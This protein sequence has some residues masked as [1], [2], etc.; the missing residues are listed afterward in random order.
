MPISGQKIPGR[1]GRLAPSP[2]GALHLGGAAT[3]L[4][5]WLDAR[6]AGSSLVLRMEDIDRP[7]VVPGAEK[8]LIED[9]RW[10][11]ID[12]DEGPD[13]GGQ[14]GPY[15]QSERL[16]LYEQILTS[17]VDRKLVYWCDCSR[18]EIARVSSAPHLGE[19]GPPYP[20]TCRPYGLQKRRWKR[21]PAL[22]FAVPPQREIRFMD[23]VHGEQREVVSNSI[24]DFILRRGDGVF[25]YQFVVVVDDW[26]MGIES[27]IRGA[28]LL[29]STARQILLQE[30]M[31]SNIPIYLHTPILVDPNGQRLA[32]R[33]RGIPIADQR[34]AGRS[35]E[36][37]V[38]KLAACIGLH[39]DATPCTAKALLE[40]YNPINLRRDIV[41]LPDSLLVLLVTKGVVGFW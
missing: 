30:A 15:R 9:L 29:N 5:T 18:A 34:A 16:D 24:G 1:R 35:S 27:V 13:V 37:V 17:F 33:N 31:G 41:R 8:A 22:R 39:K 10:L 40:D 4:V 23:R 6:S 25:A 38:G 12:W 28:D 11:G 20:G 2:T 26:K 36:E 32:K 3:F 21:P 14:A 19:E 7:R